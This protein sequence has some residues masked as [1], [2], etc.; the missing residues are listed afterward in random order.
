MNIDAQ[1][2]WAHRI[3][4]AVLASC[5]LGVVALP[6]EAEATPADRIYT[7]LVLGCAVVS[8][9]CRQRAESSAA[10][11]GR[12]L[13]YSIGRFAF[14]CATGPIAIAVV[15][16]GHSPREALLYILAG[17]L[18]AL[19]PPGPIAPPSDD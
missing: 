17:V 12:R 6:A 3:A 13:R 2:Q 15:L 10:T 1:L 8:M 4:L 9:L 11:P 5:A 14:A 7:W 16:A 18:F 19:R